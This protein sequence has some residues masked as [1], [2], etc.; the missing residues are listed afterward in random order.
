MLATMFGG[1]RCYIVRD[2]RGDVRR[3]EHS[4]TPRP[5]FFAL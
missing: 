5:D 3:I 1:I 4:R 2:I